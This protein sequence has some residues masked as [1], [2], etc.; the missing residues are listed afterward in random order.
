M[1]AS[2][3]KKETAASALDNVE[4]IYPLTPLQEGMVFHAIAKPDTTMH[5]GR[6]V[7]HLGGKLDMEMFRRAWREVLARHPALRTAFVWEGLDAPMQVVRKTLEMPVR[8]H[9]W[10]ALSA[11]ESEKKLNDWLWQESIVGFDLAAAPLCRVD[12]FSLAAD[13][14][15]M[16][17]ACH[18]V[19]ADGWSI[20]IALEELLSCANAH[21]TLLPK[22]PPYRNHIAWLLRRDASA[23]EQ[24]WRRYL[25]GFRRQS[26]IDAAR[27][28]DQ[29]QRSE[30][31]E[32]WSH[33]IDADV[34]SP[35]VSAAASSRVTLNTLFQAAWAL[36]LSRYTSADDVVFG[37][38]SSGRP[39]DVPDIERMI[40]LLVTTTPMRAK[41]HHND[42]VRTFLKH[43][44]DDATMIRQHEQAPLSQIQSWSDVPPGEAL[45]DCLYVF[46]NYPPAKDRQRATLHLRSLD[47]KAPSTFP[48]ALLI[49]P[50]GKGGLVVSTV[51]DPSRF[52]ISLGEQLVIAVVETAKAIARDVDATL[53]TIDDLP[54]AERQELTRRGNG[55]DLKHPVDDVVDMIEAMA[56]LHP[57]AIA[58]AD[59]DQKLTYIELVNTAQSAART[60]MDRGV[61]LGEPVI[62]HVDRGPKAIVG[63]LA[64]LMAGAA[65][66]PLD[67]TYPHARRV[68]II[69]DSQARIVVVAGASTQTLDQLDKVDLDRIEAVTEELRTR[70]KPPPETPA[71]II[72]TSGSTGH[73]KGVVV[74]RSNLAYSNGARLSHYGEPP[75]AFLLMSSLS[76]DSSV[77]GLF[78]TLSTGGTLV[79]AQH[80][81][82]QNVEHLTALIYRYQVTHLLCLP[83]LYAILIDYGDPTKLASLSHAIVAGETCPAAL[84]V[85]HRTVLPAARLINEYGPTEATVWCTVSDIT[86]MPTNQV[87]SI[88]QPIPGTAIKLVDHRGRQTPAAVPGEIMV[89]GPGV[90]LGY[91]GKPEMTASRFPLEPGDSGGRFYRTGDVARWRTDGTLDYLGRRDGQLKMRGHRVEIA[92]IEAVLTAISGTASAVIASAINENS[93]RLTA[94]VEDRGDDVGSFRPGIASRLPEAMVPQTIIALSAMPMLPNGKVDRQELTK[95]AETQTV[96][97]ARNVYQPPTNPTETALVRIWERVLKVKQVGIDD[98]F[99]SLGGDSLTSIRIVSLARR[100]GLDVKPTSVLEFPTIQALVRSMEAPLEQQQ[101]SRPS[102]RKTFFMVQGGE[103]MRECLEDALREHH[104]VHLLEDHWNDG[105]LSPLTSVDSMADDYLVQLR[106]IS[107]HGPYRLGGYSIGAAASVEMARRLLAAGEEVE[108]L[109]LLDP[110]DDMDFLGRVRGLDKDT[111]KAVSTTSSQLTSPSIVPEIGQRFLPGWMVRACNVIVRK[112]YRYVRGPFRLAQGSLAYSLGYRLSPGAAAHYAWIVY[113]FAIQRHELS[114]YSGRLLVFRSLLGRDTSCRYLWKELAKGRYDEEHFYCEHIAFRRDLTIVKSWTQRLAAKLNEIT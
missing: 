54:V 21:N 57:D 41:I 48:L 11:S 40:G 66:V 75:S 19:I 23:D 101:E 49:D 62:V 96:Q 44:Q 114:P 26:V 72:Y 15:R 97:Q 50:D 42:A 73:P 81:S 82:E 108:V 99:F 38:V 56:T 8:H 16:V 67:P 17:W 80:R 110:P 58:V 37:V 3:L 74:S 6:I 25:K 5:V 27:P 13:D 107:P 52:D 87:P 36:V 47:I 104:A 89:G 20:G 86:D 46:G 100:E 79:I 22:A 93:V 1:T 51:T 34:L 94:F 102:P 105:C 2:D 30:R 10:T 64:V 59:H 70:S 12:V 68:A 63:I 76:F 69:E 77:A 98:D 4:D 55:G 61:K 7:C 65:Y 33:R 35:I 18:H 103:R 112:Y 71:Y 92:E 91:F 29:S 113:N 24:F 32:Y 9:D 95:L 111:L 45:F 83:S 88:G 90:A 39:D 53:A 106:N 78:W 109:F 28:S 31:R 14:H 84:P 85:R 60:L 43:L